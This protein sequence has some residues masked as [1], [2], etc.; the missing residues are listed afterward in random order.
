MELE[1][2]DVAGRVRHRP[3]DSDLNPTIAVKNR[4]VGIKNTQMKDGQEQ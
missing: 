4:K 3:T 2:D 1:G